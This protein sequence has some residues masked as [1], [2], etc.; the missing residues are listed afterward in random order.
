MQ[1]HHRALSNFQRN[2]QL[3]SSGGDCK[4]S[5]IKKF[6]TGKSGKEQKLYVKDTS[7]TQ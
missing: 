1:V 4:D 7:A 3:C 5:P 6:I 2:A